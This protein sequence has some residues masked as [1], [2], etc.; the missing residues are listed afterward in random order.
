MSES[1]VEMNQPIEA[2]PPEAKNEKRLVDPLTHEVYTATDD[3]LVKVH[4]PDTG[5]E[6]IFSE[7]GEWRSGELRYANRQLLGWMGRMSSRQARK[8]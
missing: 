3:G 4:D 7:T 2:S 6:G 5:R 1:V 8:A